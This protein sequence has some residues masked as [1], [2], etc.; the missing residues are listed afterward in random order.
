MKLSKISS[1]F[2]SETMQTF[3]KKLSDGTFREFVDDWK[4]IFAYSKRYKWFVVLYTALGLFS[5]TLGVASSYISAMTINIITGRETDK[6]A[7]LLCLMFGTTLFYIGFSAFSNRVHKKISIYVHNDIQAEIFDRIVDVKWNELYRY[8]HGDLL[9]RFTDDVNAVSDNAISWIPDIIV[10][11]YTFVVTFVVLYKMDRI[12]AYIGLCS[13]PFLFFM[14]RA[15]MRQ[16]KKYRKKVLELNS[17]IMSFQTETFYNMD[18]IKAFGVWRVL[19]QKLRMWQKQYKKDNLEYNTFQIKTNSG[20]S[21][22]NMVV[23]MGSFCYCLYRLWNGQILYGD[24]TFFLSQRGSLTYRFDS[25]VHTIPTMLNAAIST[26][27]L[28]EIVELP[29]EEHNEESYDQVK[30]RAEQGLSVEVGDMSFA[31]NGQSNVYEHADFSAHPGEVVAV[32]GESGSGKSTLFRLLLGMLEPQS[33]EILLRDSQG[34]AIP[35][36]A[37]LRRLIAYVPQ[38][39]TMILGT[40]AE[41][42]RIVKPEATEEE[43]IAALK[44]ACAWEFVEKIGINT[45]LHERGKGISEGQAQRLSVARALLRD[46]PILLLDEATSA[47]DEKTESALISNVLAAAPNKTVIVSTHRLSMLVSCDKIFKITDKKMEAMNI[48][49]H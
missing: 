9:N 28:R 6:L 39:N 46:A 30:V 14:S 11:I 25:L 5:S 4:W 23:S 16:Q 49:I 19:S 44:T 2:Q 32:V 29:K 41:N 26:H 7:L 43:I 33:G 24:M 21:L 27:R 45:E 13:A 47:L 18:T 17:D 12:M 37:D 48:S 36:N 3:F 15:I 31:Y 35:M 40:I 38:G 20:L 42:M 22:L 1:H 34:E 8:K 10:N